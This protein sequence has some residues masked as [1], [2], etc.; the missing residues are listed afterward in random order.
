MTSPA[1]TAVKKR[2]M[3]TAGDDYYFLMYNMLILA[4]E[5]QCYSIEKAFIDHRKVA[6]LIEF[7]SNPWHTKL[8]V[9]NKGK[10]QLLSTVDRSELAKSYANG[11]ARIHLITRLLFA[12]ERKQIVVLH[13]GSR[14][15][16]INFSLNSSAL[17]HDF[18][19]DPIFEI[20]RSNATQPR[21]LIHN[22]RMA[23]L[24]KVLGRLF[25]ENGVQVW[26]V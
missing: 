24:D 12:A 9:E 4:S 17:P 8:V 11:A 3:F 15:A 10:T 21:G 13:P 5:L 19:S 23:T 18:L 2:M 25:A 7:I 6:F 20:E 1:R 22:L 14:G 16:S 26:H